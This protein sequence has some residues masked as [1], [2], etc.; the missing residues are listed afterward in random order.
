MWA[1]HAKQRHNIELTWK[2][3]EVQSLLAQGY[4]IHYGARSIKY[5]VDRRVVTLLALSHEQGLLQPN[6]NVAV[7]VNH[8]DSKNWPILQH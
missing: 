3:P 5:E 8:H 1:K 7:S 4:D 6:C 2:V